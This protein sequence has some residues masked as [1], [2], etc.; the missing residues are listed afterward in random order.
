[1]V[2][3]TTDGAHGED[4][5]LEETVAGTVSLVTFLVGFGL[6]ALGVDGFWIA[7]PV[8]F[9]GVLPLSVGLVRLY[10]GRATGSVARDGHGGIPDDPLTEL[11][12]RYAR[13]E[14]SDEE[15]ERKV[16]LLL[17]TGSVADARDA[18]GRTGG[19]FTGTDRSDD[20]R[21]REVE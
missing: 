19:R 10:R 13:G 3:M 20:R 8:G 1:M 16:E 5:P 12:S 21:E 14:L 6:L 17:E 2:Q 11:R 4:D 9:A 15:F 7:F 18:V